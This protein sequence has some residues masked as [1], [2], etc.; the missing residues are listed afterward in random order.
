MGGSSSFDH[1]L[2]HLYNLDGSGD[3][4][5]DNNNNNNDDN[6]DG[7]LTLHI[8]SG[9][10]LRIYAALPRPSNSLSSVIKRYIPF[11]TRQ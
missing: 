1:V 2:V 10:H 3:D 8:R 5:D 7:S 6:N 9:G 4:D 11:R